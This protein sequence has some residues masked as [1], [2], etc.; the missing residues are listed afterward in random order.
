MNETVFEKLRTAA[1]VL[2]LDFSTE[3]FAN[4]AEEHALA[5]E[6]I[7][8]VQ[9]VFTHLSEKKRQTTMVM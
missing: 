2:K 4:F 1:Q 3:E 9:E 7:V 8:A 6:T 5:E